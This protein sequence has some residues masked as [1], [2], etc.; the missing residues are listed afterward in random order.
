MSILRTSLLV[1]A[2]GTA[3]VLLAA[4]APPSA[5]PSSGGDA[6][7]PDE[8]RLG[9]FPNF[10]HAPAIIALENGYLE[11]EL[12]DV[13]LAPTTFNAGPAAVEALFSEAV[14]MTFIG[15]NPTITGFVRSDGDAIR[16]VAG[17]ASGGAALVVREGIDDVDDL[18]GTVLATPQLGNTQDVALRFWLR[19]NGLSSTLEGGGD[20]SVVPQENAT[21]L[22]AFVGGQIDGAWVPEPW[23]T[24]LV[25][26]GGGRVL[27]D[28][29][30]LWPDGRFVVTNLVSSRDFL[31]RYPATVSAVIRAELRALDFITSDPDSA[32]AVVNDHLE[33]LTG[34]ALD[35]T[36]LDEAW[37]NVEFTVDPLVET[38]LAS[39]EHATAVGLLDEADLDGLYALD[40]LNEV[41]QG[42]GDS[43]VA[44]P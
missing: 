5:G 43:P 17:A 6:G 11:E 32:K 36:Y 20:V 30:S 29:A 28:E 38:L 3:L 19:E 26:E 35:P 41:L 10:T 1:S 9:Y 39:A 2:S 40:P 14:D 4:C 7:A 22:Q 8:I 25:A 13:A 34:S 18:D 33:E 44:L 42:R 15:P 12:G 31:E 23:V 21:T 24:R 37:E 16:V 27:V